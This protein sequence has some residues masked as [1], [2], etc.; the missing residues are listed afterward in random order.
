[1]KRLYLE[2]LFSNCLI[3]RPSNIFGLNSHIPP[4]RGLLNKLKK[5]ID[6]DLKLKLW[7]NYHNSF[8]FLHI[9]DFLDI[10]INFMTKGFS[11]FEIYN[12]GSGKA[13]SLGDIFDHHK[14]NFST[15]NIE[16][17]L[18]EEKIENNYLDISKLKNYMNY[19][20]QHNW[21]SYSSN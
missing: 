2:N 21:K 20:F 7:G 17:A 5:N 3:L 4:R 16:L 1:M 8:D 10:F 14:K 12:V 9:S 15:K 19:S 6:E 11:N 18:N 13:V